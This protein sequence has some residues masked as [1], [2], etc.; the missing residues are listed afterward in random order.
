MKRFIWRCVFTMTV[1]DCLSA[2]LKPKTI[3]MV[4]D[5][6]RMRYRTFYSAQDQ[7]YEYLAE[8]YK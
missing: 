3:A 8:L 6:S 1:I 5:A 2:W 4:I 7:A